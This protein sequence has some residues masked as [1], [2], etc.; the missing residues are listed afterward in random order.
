MGSGKSVNAALTTALSFHY[1][2]LIG[3]EK[4]F[5]LEEK[6]AIWFEADGDVS[7][8]S[9]D[10]KKSVQTE[11]KNYASALTDHHENFWNTLKNWLDPSFN[12]SD[13][14]VLVLHTTQAFGS[15][16]RLKNW[17][18]QSKKQRLQ[19][20]ND[21]YSERT[22]AQLNAEKVPNIIKLQKTVM[23]TDSSLLTSVIGKVTLFTEADEELKL[24]QRLLKKLIGIP[25]NNRASYLHGL[26]GFVYG[27]ANKKSWS[28]TH[29]SFTEKCQH[30]TSIY[31]KKTFTFPDFQ[32]NEAT[33][34]E[35]EEHQDHLF[36]EKIREIEH[37]VMIPD[38][39]GNWLEL[40]NSLLEEL[41]ESALYRHVTKSYQKKLVKSFQYA[42]S[43]AQIEATDMIKS[44]KLLY[45]T[46][47]K[48][49]PIDIGDG[50]P[51]IEYKNGLIHNAMNE[52]SI[53][54]K[55]K[56]EP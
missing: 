9:E 20:L 48:E 56:V 47:M 6:Q 11:V 5:S 8:I 43:S 52:L 28:I 22:D 36:V 10:A 54:I 40:Q 19:T 25:E 37:H 4:C 51:P 21:I 16:T 14:G 33:E 41:D 35:V 17:N 46:T 53:N 18:S 27:Q 12:H 31:C 23:G 39:I 49:L 24:T 29:G 50:T 3:L 38:A 34:L 1:Q 7:F 55:W 42:Y 15:K 2:A 13:Y 30:L 26:V 32:G 45:N 44:S